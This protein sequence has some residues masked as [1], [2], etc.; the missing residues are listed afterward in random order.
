[1]YTFPICCFTVKKIK[2]GHA[3]GVTKLSETASLWASRDFQIGIVKTPRLICRIAFLF[4]EAQ[5]NLDRGI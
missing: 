3:S 5:Q 1:M 2:W 4:V